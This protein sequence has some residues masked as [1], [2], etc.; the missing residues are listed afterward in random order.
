M[1][2]M[3]V[4]AQHVFDFLGFLPTINIWSSV[5]LMLYENKNFLCDHT[6]GNQCIEESHILV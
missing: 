4:F 3:V 6:A 1:G 5:Q 2:W